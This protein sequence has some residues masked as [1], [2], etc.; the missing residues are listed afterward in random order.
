M[1]FRQEIDRRLQLINESVITDEEYD[2]LTI[3]ANPQTVDYYEACKAVISSR[4]T[5]GASLARLRGLALAID[6]L[7]FDTV[8]EVKSN[9]LIG[10]AIED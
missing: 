10:V 3:P 7:V 6:N 9:I 2:A 8:V 5:L 4:G 1:T